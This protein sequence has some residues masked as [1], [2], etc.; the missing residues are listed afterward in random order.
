MFGNGITL[1]ELDRYFNYNRWPMF[2]WTETTTT[3]PKTSVSPENYSIDLPGYKKDQIKI[4]ISDGL[5]Y[6]SANNESKGDFNYQFYLNSDVDAAKITTKLEDG[7]LTIN[8]PKT[9]K[10]KPRQITVS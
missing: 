5:L 1:R 6:I 9:D 7:V 4:E 8:L 3:L 2:V 10:A